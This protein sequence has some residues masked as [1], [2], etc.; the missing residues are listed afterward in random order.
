[1]FAEAIRSS[2]ESLGMEILELTETGRDAV[3]AAHQQPDL[4]LV[5]LGLPDMHGIE[6]GKAILAQCPGAT[7][8]AVTSIM[9]P[10][11]VREVMRA[12]FHGYLTKDTPL[13]QFIKS[14]E[15]ALS[16][17]MVI[18]QHLAS[19]A[20]GQRTKEQQETDLL[21]RQLTARELEILALLAQGKSG[22]A[23]AA[24]LSISANTI[25]SHIQNI[26]TKLQ[27][28]SRLEAATFAVKHGI[29]Q[30]ENSR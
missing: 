30:V 13:E 14:I 8:L 1:L 12:G 10:A 5:D 15:A 3:A 11:I 24:E 26:L 2:L 7:V 27:V 28:H 17:Q 4:V 29:V 16:G 23:M 21:V 6:V 25:R 9:D 19:R 18:P 22:G 20:A